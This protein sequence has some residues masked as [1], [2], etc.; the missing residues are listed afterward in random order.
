MV[1]NAVIYRS[2]KLPSIIEKKGEGAYATISL[3]NENTVLK[4]YKGAS[5]PAIDVLMEIAILRRTAGHPNIVEMTGVYLTLETGQFA[6]QM[7]YYP[8][9]LLQWT[10][11]KNNE[12]HTIS[13]VYQVFYAISYLHSLN[14]MHGDV[15]PENILMDGDTPKLCDFGLSSIYVNMPTLTQT[16]FCGI[17]YRPPEVIV[18]SKKTPSPSIDIWSCAVLLWELYE[19]DVPF[20]GENSNDQIKNIVSLLGSPTKTNGKWLIPYLEKRLRNKLEDNRLKDRLG[21]YYNIIISMLHYDGDK[22][23][24]INEVMASSVFDNVRK[25]GYE[26]KNKESDIVSSSES[27]DNELLQE[28]KRTWD[29]MNISD[30]T[31]KMSLHITKAY[32]KEPLSNMSNDKLVIHLLTLAEYMV[33][34]NPQHNFEPNL[35]NYEHV[36]SSIEATNIYERILNNIHQFI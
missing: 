21:P 30:R 23:P 5:Q 8:Y 25:D 27:M 7:P 20:L 9:N 31:R 14:I 17:Y 22:R 4:T 28:L 15:K 26:D 16:D 36:N 13:V 3:L 11:N 12:E 19:G 6:L 32:N 24:S 1:N 10:K 2:S 33:N 34:S 18:L 35:V 29:L